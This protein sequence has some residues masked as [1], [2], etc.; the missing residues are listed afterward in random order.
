MPNNK[1]V[2]T[3]DYYNTDFWNALKGKP[4]NEKSLL[5]GK[6]KA[7]GTYFFPEKDE[8]MLLEALCEH[9]PLRQIC[10]VVAGCDGDYTLFAYKHHS[11]AKWVK[12]ADGID[13]ED[14]TGK[15]KRHILHSHRLSA[16]LQFDRDFMEETKGFQKLL[17]TSIAKTL[18]KGEIEGF[19]YGKNDLEPTGLLHPDKGAKPSVKTKEINAKAL[20]ELFLSVPDDYRKNARWVFSD[21]TAL[22][23]R[24]LKDDSGRYL[25]NEA[26]GL[27][28]GKPV[29]IINEMPQI[30]EGNTP[31]LFGDFSSYWIVPRRTPTIRPL[32]ELYALENRI[33]YLCMEYLEAVLIHPEAICAMQMISI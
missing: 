21:K 12:P 16:I 20:M 32:T 8:K 7:N 13:P 14:I 31:I 27:L 28:L 22:V 1:V 3:T 30:Q 25:W 6:E 19:L 5:F 24:M 2:L 33:A 26:D 11:K 29:T 9:N 18:A 15:L 4:H 10:T 17:T 23:V